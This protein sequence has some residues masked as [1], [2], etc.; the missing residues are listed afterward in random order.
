MHN[1][2]F[3]HGFTQKA[4]SVHLDIALSVGEVF[5]HSSKGPLKSCELTV[6]TCE[7][8]DFTSNTLKGLLI[9]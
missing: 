4:D 5:H 2:I 3:P 1:L 9:L 7:F 6:W 8:M